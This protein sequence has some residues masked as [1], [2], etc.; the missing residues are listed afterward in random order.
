M[1][2]SSFLISLSDD[3]RDDHE[4]A[5]AYFYAFME[6][7]VMMHLSTI[8]ICEFEVKQRITDLGLHNFIILPFNYDDAMAGAAA[9]SVMHP[10]RVKNDDRAA[11][12]ADAKILGQCITGGISFFATGDQKCCARIEG[13]RGQASGLLLPQPISTKLPYDGSWFNNG[14]HEIP[15]S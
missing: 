2:D 7:S 14:Q 4:V 12:S 6:N 11:V 15:I 1:L 13:M 10:T 3:G 9:F 8:V 5:K